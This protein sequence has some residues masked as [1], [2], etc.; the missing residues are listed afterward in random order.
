MIFR[1]GGVGSGPGPAD[2]GLSAGYTF[3]GQFL[4]H[5]I[6]FDPA[7]SLERQ[8]DPDAL[9]DYRTPRFDLDSVYGRGPADQPYLYEDD[10]QLVKLVL[11]ARLDNKEG[12]DVPR[13]GSIHRAIIGD[14]RNDEN[15]II[16][17]LHAIFLLLH[18][19]I[20]KD[21]GD[22]EKAQREVRWR[23]QWVILYDFLKHIVNKD[24]YDEVLPH[25]SLGSNIREHPPRLQFYKPRENAFIPIEFSAAAYRFGHSTVREIYKLNP[26]NGQDFKMFSND[27]GT[28]DLRG[29]HS[30][31]GSWFVDWS[32][33][34][35]GISS[36]QHDDLQRAHRIGPS[37]V[38][39]LTNLPLFVSPQRSLFE[40]NMNS[41]A[42]VNL[43]RGWRMDL[44][45]GQAVC[46]AL[47]REPIPDEELTV[48]TPGI[49]LREISPRGGFSKNA[50][51]WYYILRE[52]E[53]Y[54][55]DDLEKEKYGNGARLGPVGGRIVMETF[56]GLLLEDG[57]SYLRQNPLWKPREKD[58][59]SFG[60]ADLIQIA[61]GKIPRPPTSNE[62]S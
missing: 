27:E 1:D 33:F 40:Q 9:V 8:N 43:I 34:F 15:I 18:N 16:A 41:L 12:F 24:T 26:G 19:R 50:P 17:Q 46:H 53:K 38:P 49:P 35:E 39:S 6:T 60:I 58:P 23:Y 3:F 21:L 10:D 52:A 59:D 57:H 55:K 42:I 54:G 4:T 5:D 48:G 51:L 7:S 62:S 14:P 47:G 20:V 56:V 2:S 25:V 28:P 32:L 37:L 29:G 36:E 31:N 13:V 45:S 30:F 44:P 11:G 61:T 22:F